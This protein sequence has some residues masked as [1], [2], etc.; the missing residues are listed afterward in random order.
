MH[1]VMQSLAPEHLPERALPAAA[2]HWN[3]RKKLS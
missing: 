3:W 1:Y 2:G